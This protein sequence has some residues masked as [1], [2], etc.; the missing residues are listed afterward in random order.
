MV[1]EDLIFSLPFFRQ[2]VA[3]KLARW[4]INEF[5]HG[6]YAHDYS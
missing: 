3:Q 1:K 2:K 4:K 5:L 6:F